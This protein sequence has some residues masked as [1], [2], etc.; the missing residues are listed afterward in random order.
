MTKGKG[1]LN[2][3][4]SYAG[5]FLLS[6]S[7]HHSFTGNFEE[8]TLSLWSLS[9]PVGGRPTSSRSNSGS[10]RPLDP[11]GCTCWRERD[12]GG[13]GHPR[14]WARSFSSCRQLKW[15]YE[16]HFTVPPPSN[17]RESDVFLAS[18][19]A[20]QVLCSSYSDDTASTSS[21]SQS[22][23]QLPT[24]H[25]LAL[26]L[27]RL[28]D[29]PSPLSGQ[30]VWTSLHMLSELGVRRL[31]WWSYALLSVPPRYQSHWLSR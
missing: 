27:V 12:R 23:C 26:H 21:D 4:L 9:A 10:Q 1:E 8:F 5:G 6:W 25:S 14:A 20:H 29:S 11:R 17:D 7:N 2:P 31:M 24:I 22:S 15:F 30:Q 16:W 28:L 19:W 18:L 3:L 13:W